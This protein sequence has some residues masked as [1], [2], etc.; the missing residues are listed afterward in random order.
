[1][2]LEGA[3][4]GHPHNVYVQYIL[5]ADGNITAKR[6]ERDADALDETFKNLN[7]NNVC[8]SRQTTA[9][10][11]CVLH[12]II[13]CTAEVKS[14][15]DSVDAGMDHQALVMS[16]L[17]AK[18]DPT[19]NGTAV[20]LHVHNKYI[21]IQTMH[22]EPTGCTFPWTSTNSTSTVDPSTSSTSTVDPSTSSTSIVNP[23]TS[24]TGREPVPEFKTQL[25]RRCYR[26]T[27]FKLRSTEAEE[28]EAASQAAKT[29][30]NIQVVTGTAS[31]V[32]QLG[33]LGDGWQKQTFFIQPEEDSETPPSVH[34]RFQAYIIAVMQ[35]IFKLKEMFAQYNLQDDSSQ[36]GIGTYMT[37]VWSNNTQVPHKTTVDKSG[38]P[39]SVQVFRYG[40]TD[41][42]KLN[43][44]Q[45]EQWCDTRPSRPS[46]A[47]PPPPKKQ[48][49][50]QT[51]QK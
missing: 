12:G 49:K 17:F 7:N 14:S 1:M 29:F 25:V 35:A 41:E 33:G 42:K 50:T 37:T 36:N 19:I 44:W 22:R 8:P 27:E 20:G 45:S 2:T 3:P 46:V 6:I 38:L 39:N 47:S 15:S 51:P 43:P 26:S 24:S 11:V 10:G 21:R 18:T 13:L 9:D 40:A 16:D 30:P 48:K 4:T 28:D 23:S 5:T 32:I 34:S 31:E